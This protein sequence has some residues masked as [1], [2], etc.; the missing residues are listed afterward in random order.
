VRAGERQTIIPVN[1][2]DAMTVIVE[3]NAGN[4]LIASKHIGQGSLRQSSR[5]PP[6]SAPI[7][8]NACN[9]NDGN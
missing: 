3:D 9:S 5:L 7:P 6:F 8:C 1:P 2:N 4:L